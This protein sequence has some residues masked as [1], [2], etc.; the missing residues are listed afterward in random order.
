MTSRF[1]A[2][3]K[4]YKLF[5]AVTQDNDSIKTFFNSLILF[6]LLVFRKVGTEHILKGKKLSWIMSQKRVTPLPI[7]SRLCHP[8]LKQEVSNRKVFCISQISD[9]TK[10]IINSLFLFCLFLFDIMR[11][12]YV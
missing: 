9:Y 3:F 10:T 8:D 7:L 12:G 6:R 1:Q 11:A 2:E 5:C 4:K